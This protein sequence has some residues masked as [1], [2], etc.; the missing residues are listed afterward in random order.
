MMNL[1][2]HQYSHGTSHLTET[3]GGASV[4]DW[5][6]KYKIPWDKL[7]NQFMA[8]C[9]KGERPDPRDR[10]EMIRIIADDVMQIS[11]NPKRKELQKNC[12]T[13]CQTLQ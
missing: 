5:S 13:A 8:S 4:G 3:P 1:H 6:M 11:T 2:Q 10:R 12:T 7:P 9:T